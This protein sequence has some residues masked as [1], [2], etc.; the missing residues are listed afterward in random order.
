M[1][2]KRALSP[3]LSRRQSIALGLAAAAGACASGGESAPAPESLNALARAKGMRFGAAMGAGGNSNEFDDPRFQ[4]LVIE[5]CGVLVAENEHKWPFLEP[6]P[7]R[8]TFERADQMMA[9]A[10]ARQIPFRGHN[11]VWHHE[12]WLP[13]WI[14]E[15]DFGAN[16]RA[17]AE[18]VV[19]NHV[20]T[21]CQHYGA[22]IQSWDV[23]NETVHEQTGELRETALTR[24]AGYEINEFIF[25]VARE[26]APHAQMVYNDY[27]TGAASS[28]NHRAGVLRALQHWKSRGVHI[29]ALGIQGHIGA[30]RDNPDATSFDASQE[31]AWRAFLD[32]VTGMGLKLLITELDVGDRGMPADIPA[33][34]RLMADYAKAFLDVTLSYPQMGDV[35]CWGLVDH[36]SWLQNNSPR[37]DG[38]PKRPLPFDANYQP[39][40]MRE[41]IAA[42]FRGAPAR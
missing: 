36:Y 32:E 8:F 7:G 18:R 1:S 24:A 25:H 2:E 17:E 33:R 6:A 11:L 12:R 34:D 21:V 40:P 5:E 13:R 28:A 41:A 31:A 16:P 20:T 38:L 30:N 39:K 23:I 4:Q 22:R 10:D 14:N 35:L 27:M 19:R 3:G 37:D 26:A 42:A 15:Y 9:W 29:D